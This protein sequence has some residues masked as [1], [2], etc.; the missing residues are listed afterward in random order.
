LHY[1][2]AVLPVPLADHVESILAANPVFDGLP[3]GELF[4]SNAFLLRIVQDAWERFLRAQGIVGNRIAE[5]RPRDRYSRIEIP[6]DHPDIRTLIDSM[7]MDGALHP[8]VAEQIPGDLP[9]WM[10]VG[11]VRDPAALRN[12]VSDGLKALRDMMP[13]ADSTHGDWGAFARRFAEILPRF[14]SLDAVRAQGVKAS[15]QEVQC[16]ADERL[17]AWVD[18]HF[19]DLP[20]LPVAKGPVMVHQVSRFL[21][22]QRVAGEARIALLAFDGL[23]IDQWVQI[24]EHLSKRGEDLVFD[25][26][27][28]FAWLPT[29]TAVSRQALFAGLKPREFAASLETTANEPKLWSRFWQEQGLRANEVFYRKGIRQTDQLD[30]LEVDLGAVH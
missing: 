24:R 2:N 18:K 28:C 12:L 15:L 4:S 10:S 8:V 23:A 9:S 7:F 20:S 29:L 3:I 25:E 13:T 1:R 5:S 16:L 30:G 6:F 21:A 22:L 26:G 11:L 14:H 27:A 19:A 17:V